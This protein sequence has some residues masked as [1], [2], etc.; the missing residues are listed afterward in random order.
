[1]NTSATEQALR[2]LSVDDDPVN[3]MLIRAIVE[4]TDHEVVRG[5]IMREAATLAEARRVLAEESVDVVLLDV[6]LPDGLGLDLAA[7]LHGGDANRPAIV[8]LTASVL[9]ADQQAA[10]DAG[11]DAFLAKPYA[12]AAL[13]STVAE[14][15]RGRRPPAFGL[16]GRQRHDRPLV[17]H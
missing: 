11:C 9:P 7:S 10:L 5:A 3:R 8:A 13:I 14:V 17:D 2:I 12:A 16:I 15:V 6:H 1:M 4:R